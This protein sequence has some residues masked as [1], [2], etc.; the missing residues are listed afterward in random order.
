MNDLKQKKK[1][2]FRQ[3]RAASL[4]VAGCKITHIAKLLEVRRE[5]I[6]AWKQQPRFLK[7]VERLQAEFLDEVHRLTMP[8]ME[9]A[10]NRLGKM[11]KSSDLKQVKFAI[12]KIFQLNGKL[13]WGSERRRRA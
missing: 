5:T 13:P 9:R 11:L 8:L 1:L 10:L 4:L 12:V 3:K 6:W 7:R 2:S